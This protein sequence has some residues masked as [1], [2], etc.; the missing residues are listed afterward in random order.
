MKKELE[1]VINREKH[2]QQIEL[3]KNQNLISEEKYLYLKDMERKL[4]AILAEWKK[5][6]DKK[7]VIKMMQS[8]LF[9]QRET[10]TLTK[11]QKRIET[12]YVE[13]TEPVKVGDKV[14]M[15]ANRQVGVVIN[16]RGKKA[17]V[18]VGAIPI[19]V[20]YTDL[21]VIHDKKE[22]AAS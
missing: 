2:R 10:Q 9:K 4:K 20:D 16:M 19:T 13:T 21:I 12:N 5:T 17:I 15:K 1:E 6:D 11:Q 22:T 7:A 8:L 18:Q 3:L 14:K